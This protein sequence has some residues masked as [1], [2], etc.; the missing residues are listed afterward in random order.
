[1]C[2]ILFILYYIL[3]YYIILYYIIY[4][5]IC[6][7]CIIF[8]YIIYKLEVPARFRGPSSKKNDE[9]R[10]KQR[11]AEVEKLRIKSY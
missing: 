4:I 11:G 6:I 2:I 8:Y 3:F 10:L 5:Y 7:Y 1:M 9:I